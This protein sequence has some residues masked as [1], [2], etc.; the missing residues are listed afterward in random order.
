MSAE[1]ENAMTFCAKMS[2]G[3]ENKR[4]NAEIND[5]PSAKLRDGEPL[6]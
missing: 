5:Q 6:R 2:A 4:G 1:I 3:I